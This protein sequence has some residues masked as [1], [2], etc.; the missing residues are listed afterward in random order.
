MHA[1]QCYAAVPA[2]SAVS[3]SEG[4]DRQQRLCYVQGSYQEHALGTVDNPHA[5]KSDC[6]SRNHCKG[7]KLMRA[8]GMSEIIPMLEQDRLAP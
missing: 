7:L 6:V 1:M 3:V 8:M 4:A 5:D 2:N